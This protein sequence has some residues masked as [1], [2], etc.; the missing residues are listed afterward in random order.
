MNIDVLVL[1]YYHVLTYKLMMLG[2]AEENPEIQEEVL[3]LESDIFENFSIINK[4]RSREIIREFSHKPLCD[5]TINE[6]LIRLN[7][8]GRTI[9]MGSMK[10]ENND[11]AAVEETVKKSSV[12][13]KA[14]S[15]KKITD[16]ET[17][18]KL[19]IEAREQNAPRKRVF[20]E[21][22]INDMVYTEYVYSR[23]FM[24]EDEDVNNVLND[25]RIATDSVMQLGSLVFTTGAEKYKIFNE[26]K[27]KGFHFFEKFVRENNLIG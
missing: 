5:D 15:S 25:L 27:Q 24:K 21:L 13:K 6:A 1:K 2:G 26:L 23:L 20:R 10:P 14:A 17:A 11:K 22:G 12:P 4:D 16:D 19:L 3:A 8:E 18:I 7:K 9:T